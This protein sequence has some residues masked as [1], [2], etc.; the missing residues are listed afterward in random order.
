MGSSGTR[1][2]FPRGEKGW[3][4]GYVEYSSWPTKYRICQADERLQNF[5]SPTDIKGV[6]D[7]QHGSFLAL[8][9]KEYLNLENY[10]N[11][12]DDKKK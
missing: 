5:H 3:R 9:K 4:V 8:T 10:W 2:S 12:Q 11:K 6:A 7:P 1:G